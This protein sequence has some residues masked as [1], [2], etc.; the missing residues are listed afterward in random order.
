M[1]D[2]LKYIFLIL[3]GIGIVWFLFGGPS[4]M[5]DKQQGIFIKPPSPVSSGEVYGWASFKE[6]FGIKDKV[7]DKDL[8][9]QKKM[10]LELEQAEREAL[11]IK[12]R[13]EEI[14][15]EENTSVFAGKVEI[16][17]CRGSQDDVQKEYVELKV[18]TSVNEQILISGWKLRSGMTGV[19]MQIGDAVKLPYTSR[20]YTA[21]A[22]FVSNKDEI[23]ISSGRSPIG[24]S[25]LVN[26]CSG[27]LE[28]FQDFEPSLERKCP[29]LEDENLPL[30]GPNSFN[31]DCLDYIERLSR[32]ETVTGDLPLKMQSECQNYLIENA[33]HN[34]CMDNYKNDDD[35]YQSE[36]RI[37]LGRENELWKN[38]REII[39]LVDNDGKLV[40]VC[41]Y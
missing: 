9:P 25:F 21:D 30:S 35:F 13:L 40:D 28:Y 6:F 15:K 12:Q 34:A 37:F 29:L 18:K 24:M 39:E 2:T 41:S 4:R 1:D 14:E 19:E 33:N 26:K 5:R 22:I 23:I 36:W 38:K 16:Y 10:E 20:A 8:T 3:I 32:C 11:A 31:D 27:Y 7:S 17:R